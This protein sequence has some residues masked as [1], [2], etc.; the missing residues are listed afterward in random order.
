MSPLVAALRGKPH[1]QLTA[2]GVLAQRGTRASAPSLLPL[3]TSEIPLVRYWAREALERL[4][5]R[6]LGIDLDGDTAT[7]QRDAATYLAK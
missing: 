2:A 4:T 5:G 1:E 6:P 7:I 3:L